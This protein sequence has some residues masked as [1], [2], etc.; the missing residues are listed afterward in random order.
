MT[1]L[2]RALN[3][4]YLK[5]NRTLALAMIVVAPGTVALL[6]LM[7]MLRS[8]SLNPDIEI[9]DSMIR[10][11]VTLWGLL[12]LPL[13]ITLETALLAGL[14]HQSNGWK[15]L[16]ALPVPRWSIYLAKYLIIMVVIGSSSIS[17]IVLLV[18]DGLIIPVLLPHITVN[19]GPMDWGQT[20]ANLAA[21][22]LASWLLI[23]IHTWVSIRWHS[24]TV[25]VG[26]GMAATAANFF[27]VQSDFAP[28]YPWAMPL[29]ATGQSLG[30]TT[31]HLP[32]VLTLSVVGSVI[33][34]V[35]GVVEVGRRDIQ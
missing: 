26:L 30:S 13:F 32:L 1:Y 8:V 19:Y 12:T 4:E 16:G 29:L 25:A 24:F 28:Y 17:L 15:H 7:V 22:Y 3:A 6:A 20:L 18:A 23:A 31:N 9:W 2:L 5:L 21:M 34:T 14:E 27:I 33:V 35:F 11:A 10:N